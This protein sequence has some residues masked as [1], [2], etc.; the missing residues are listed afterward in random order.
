MHFHPFIAAF[1]IPLV[2]GGF[3]MALPFLKFNEEPNGIWFYSD[4]AKSAAKFS[5][6]FALILTPRPCIDE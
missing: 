3:L 6:I 2:I 4:K 1:F 5:V